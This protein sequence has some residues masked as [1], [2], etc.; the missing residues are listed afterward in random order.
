MALELATNLAGDARA[1]LVDMEA[2]SRLDYDAL[3]QRLTMRYEPEDLTAM[4]QSQLKTRKRKRNESIPEMVQDLNRLVRKAFPAADE[5]TRNSLAV[6]SLL[7][8]LDDRQQ[9]LFVYQGNPKTVEEAGKLAMSYEAFESVRPVKSGY[10]RR[11]VEEQSKKDFSSRTINDIQNARLSSADDTQDQGSTIYQKCMEDIGRLMDKA[12]GQ[13]LSY[14][15]KP[16]VC[17]KCQGEGHIA[18]NCPNTGK[19]DAITKKTD[20]TGPG[21]KTDGEEETLLGN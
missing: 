19:G 3:A 7:S 21:P 14:R 5:G 16:I 17:F 11:Q 2:T 10:V 13:R 8:A 15:R 18:R 20:M 4:Y 1:I 12:L 6:S 9:E